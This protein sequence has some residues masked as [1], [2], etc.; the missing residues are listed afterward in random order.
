MLMFIL[1]FMLGVI[2]TYSVL[3][4]L[5]FKMAQSFHIGCREE[6]TFKKYFLGRD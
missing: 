1:G 5:V 3:E 4:F 2:I 6:L